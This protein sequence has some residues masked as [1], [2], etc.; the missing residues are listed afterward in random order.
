[1]AGARR[2]EDR[3]QESEDRSQKLPVCGSATRCRMASWGSEYGVASKVGAAYRAGRVSEM[4][5]RDTLFTQKLSRWARASL[6][7]ASRFA[8]AVSGPPMSVGST[9]MGLMSVNPMKPRAMS[10]Y[11]FCM[12]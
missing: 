6:M 7:A 4:P 9:R 8:V 10:M 12:S 1:M 5:G 3:G 11:V 2:T